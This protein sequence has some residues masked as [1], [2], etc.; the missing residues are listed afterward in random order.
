M[1]TNFRSYSSEES[2]VEID[3]VDHVMRMEDAE[4]DF[5]D[6]IGTFHIHHM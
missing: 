3:G 1:D 2:L 4:L 6:L 5:T